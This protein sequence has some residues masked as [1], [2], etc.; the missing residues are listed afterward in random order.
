MVFAAGRAESA[1][2]AGRVFGEGFPR[3]TGVLD[4]VDERR[5]VQ[6]RV[7]PVA[8]HAE[9]AAADVGDVVRLGRIRDARPVLRQGVLIG[10]LRHVRG[11]PVDVR[12]VVVLHEH[13]DELIEVADGSGEHGFGAR[14]IA[15]S[16]QHDDAPCRERHDDQNNRYENGPGRM[17]PT[18]RGDQGHQRGTGSDRITAYIPAPRRLSVLVTGV[19]NQFASAGDVRP[20]NRLRRT[21]SRCRSESERTET[22]I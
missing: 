9:R 18:D 21:E 16:R 17:R 20:R 7:V 12:E 3:V 4:D 15:R 6:V 13:H 22:R 8:T 10:E 1:S 5:V 19:G 2:A 11:M 14:R